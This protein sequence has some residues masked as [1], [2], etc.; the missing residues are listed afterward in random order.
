[1]SSIPCIFSF[2]TNDIWFEDAL[3]NN[4]TLI[5]HSLQG[6]P[7]GNMWSIW[8]SSNNNIFFGFDS[9]M[10]LHWNGN[11]FKQYNLGNSQIVYDIWGAIDPATNEQIILCVCSSDQTSNSE[12]YQFNNN[13]SDPIVSLYGQEWGYG[14][15]PVIN[16]MSS[17]III[18]IQIH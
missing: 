8:G 5:E 9:G 7:V 6:Y 1:M 14:S 3:F 12:I 10:I 17:A 11:S 2:S 16:I 4:N 13:E 18:T 15:N